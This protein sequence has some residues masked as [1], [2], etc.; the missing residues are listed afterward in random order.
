[1]NRRFFCIVS[2]LALG[3]GVFL[4][5]YGQGSKR[6]FG[7]FNR[8][9]SERAIKE[10]EERLQDAQT[11][12][13]AEE[14]LRRAEELARSED[15]KRLVELARKAIEEAELKPEEKARVEAATKMIEKSVENVSEEASKIIHAEDRFAD[16]GA[17]TPLAAAAAPAPAIET[18]E[19][20]PRT[21]GAAPEGALPGD[22][23]PE[24]VIIVEPQPLLPPPLPITPAQQNYTRI[25]AKGGAYFHASEKV[26]VFQDDVQ[27]DHK[28]FD[29]SCDKL[30]IFLYKDVKIGSGSTSSV[31]DADKAGR[32]S[33]IM[34]AIAAG[35]VVVRKD[36]PSGMTQVGKCRQ[37][38]Y[39]DLSGD[40]TMRGM[41]QVQRGSDLIIAT[42]ESTTIVFR[43][44]GNM[45]V[46]GP[47]RIDIVKDSALR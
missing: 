8:S 4:E 27:V 44:D 37:A 18:P 5:A 32:R 24:P 45:E 28:I 33:D 46:H 34:K 30:E 9:S 36:S 6:G 20:A 19:A 1:M 39:E 14:A 47:S 41:P 2:I 23:F 7:A 16:L 22:D 29:L 11:R 10:V 3:F 43:A 25:D 40:I 17:P 13:A 35:Y 26:V 38:T 12:S 42:D 31:P 21:P 15:A